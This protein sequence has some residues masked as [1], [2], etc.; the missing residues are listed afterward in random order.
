MKERNEKNTT[1][2][3]LKSLSQRMFHGKNLSFVSRNM[4]GQLFSELSSVIELGI[5]TQV[6]IGS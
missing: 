6:K 1:Y 2:M 4:N 3:Y 5:R